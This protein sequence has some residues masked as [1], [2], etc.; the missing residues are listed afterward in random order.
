[1]TDPRA[2]DV[3]FAQ[4]QRGKQTLEGSL[5]AR[6][7][8]V[9]LSSS[10]SQFCHPGVDLIL[11]PHIVCTLIT[12][13]RVRRSPVDKHG[14]ELAMKRLSC[15]SLILAFL[16]LSVS[17]S[18]LHAASA[19]SHSVPMP[20]IFETNMGQAP[21]L[22]G[23]VSR[24]G[25]VQA[26]FSKS[27]VDLLLS[28]GAHGRTGIGFRL[29]GADP[30]IAPRGRDPLPSVSHY[31]VGPDPSRWIHSVPNQSQVMYSGIYP[32]IDLIFHGSGDNL[33]HDFR[34]SAGADPARVRLSITR[35]EKVS[36]AD[37]G[38]LEV[39][40]PGGTLVF[41]K[42][43][44]YQDSPHG[45]ETVES[46]FVLNSD[47]S[48]QFRLGPYDKN[49]ELVIDPV[50][51]FSTYLAASSSDG[52][53]AVT[54]DSSGNIYVTGYTGSGFPIVDGLQPTIAGS[55]DAFVSKLDPTGHTLLYST[56]LGGS[57]GN[58]GAAIAIDSKGNIIVAGTSGSND[59]P[60]AGAVPAVTCQTN[61]TC[62]F[63]ASL[64]SNGDAFNYSGLIGGM[65][66]IVYSD[67]ENQGRLA[68][69]GT[70]NAYLASVTDDSNFDITPGTLAN[71]VPGYPYD[72][73]FVLKVDPT[74]ALIYSTIIP[75][76]ATEDPSDVLINIFFPSGISVDANGQVTIAG[77][78]G[79]GL[80]TT[81]GVIAPTFPNASVNV[82]DPSAGFVLQ[83]NATASAINYATYVPGTD[84]VNGYV[85]D[86]TGNSYLTGVT[87]ETTLPVSSNAYQK[88]IIPGEDCTCDSGFLLKLDGAGTT[89]LAAT[90][91][92]G[93]SG[94]GANFSGIALDSHSNVYVGGWGSSDFP[95]QNPFISLWEFT[96]SDEEMVLAEMNPSMSALLFGSFL[97]ST[98][99]TLPGS[100]FSG[101]T[102]DYQDNLIV[103][104]GTTTT[105]FPT[106]S[107]A[108]QTVLPAQTALLNHPFVAKLN[109]ATAAPSLCLDS[110]GVNFGQVQVNSSNTQT[111]HLTNCGNAA[112]NLASLASS[113]PTVSASE[114][115]G[116]IQPGVVCPIS[117]IYSPTTVSTV[118]G[119]VSLNGNEA[120]SP[121]SISFSGQG[122]P[123]FATSSTALLP[124]S[125]TPGGSATSTVTIAPLS[126]LNNSVALSCSSIALNGSPATTAPP[127]CS[128]SA[129]FVVNGSGTS[130]LTVSTTGSS[131]LLSP[132]S[133][134]R[135]SLLY[136]MCLP[137]AGLVLVGARLR[138]AT[139]KR[140]LLC[141]LVC[142]TF[143][144]LVWLTACGGGGSSGGGGGGGGTPA[145]T[146]TITVKGTAG[147]IGNTTNVTLTVQ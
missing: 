54:T 124:S 63:I 55:T 128:F 136:W 113:A 118:M 42:P 40:L 15:S 75:G 110:W 17:P 87:S 85:V 72:S 93:T 38:D 45:R 77:T 28:E 64:T 73:A 39:L 116:A 138:P 43:H 96:E 135:S 27:G 88:T 120:I 31:L 51:S 44:A 106:T 49:R 95:L 32:G 92:Q 4:F 5:M 21:S 24:H 52:T 133:M 71:N 76:T 83:L 90:Y 41:Q 23:F 111:V 13:C 127:A 129:V 100:T 94:N 97:S 140:R 125:V 66:G 103:T 82:V 47:D 25:N 57:S 68:V 46:G 26:L 12:V 144:G 56:Y 121:Q 11:L 84:E 33:E 37:S 80:P 34:I 67:Y 29:L 141:V 70:G 98:D 16:F 123:D 119:T 112:L 3:L 62:Y 59:F 104:G 139:S 7:A 107:G 36:L 8:L 114:T 147:S 115:C 30:D 48:V 145:G 69:D 78:A 132:A 108:F 134:L 117:V 50:F 131:A 130:T 53:T 102:V 146:Y 126:G 101:L 35:R 58:Y 142:L 2:F 20:I 60:H 105:D 81:A 91:L 74:G 79:L 86:S 89:V 122:V 19:N 9:F 61:D 6:F 22:Y 137:V 10:V 99:Q 65:Q 109:M 18:N 143:S 14:W 1:L